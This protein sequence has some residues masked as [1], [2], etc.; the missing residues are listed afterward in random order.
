MRIGARHTALY[1]RRSRSERIP[2]AARLAAYR[3][4]RLGAA[5]AW[6]LNIEQDHGKV[7][8]P[9]AL[10]SLGTRTGRHEVLTHRLERRSDGESVGGLVVNQ[11]NAHPWFGR[12]LCWSS[13]F[14]HSGLVGHN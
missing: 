5:Q 11:Q 7:G 12:D 10:Q 14:L 2:P 1:S 3:L 9:Q 4:C 13:R 8:F 6:H